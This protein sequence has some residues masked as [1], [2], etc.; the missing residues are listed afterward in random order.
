MNDEM[1]AHPQTQAN[2]ERLR[3]RGVGDRRARRSA[4]WPR[5]R[6]SGPGRMSEPETILAHAARLLR[7]AGR[8][9]R[10]AGGGDRGPDARVDRSGAGG[11]QPL[12]REDG[13]S[14]GRGGV[15]ARGRRGA[16][17]GP[18][19][20]RRAPIG[21]TRAAGRDD[22]ASSR[23]AVRE[24]LPARRRA[25]HGR[26][27]GRFPARA[28]PSDRKRARERRRAGDPDGADRPTSSSATR[29]RPAAGQRHRRLRAR[30]RRRA[31]QGA[32]QAR[33][34]GARPDRGERRARAG[35][36]LRGGHQ[37]GG[38]ARAARAR[39][40]SCRSSPSARWPR[41]FST[42]WSAPLA[43][44]RRRYLAQQIELGGAE[45][46]LGR[47]RQPRRS[48]RSPSR[49]PAEPAR[50]SS[51]RG[52]PA[53]GRADD[54]RSGR[55]ARRR[56]PGPGSPSTS[57]APVLLGNDLAALPTLDAVAERIRTTYCCELCPQS[58]QRG[59]GRGQSA[60]PG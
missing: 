16:D 7:G 59:A 55:R 46:I 39:R 53:T 42:R 22:Q 36:G 41:R 32:G 29:E 11:H 5:D 14:R 10:P 60:T 30:D 15:G 4:R 24:E 25:G 27:A 33:A 52:P 56:F 17:L 31:G 44:E 23:T 49:R 51:R 35:R 12:E 57:P 9:A 45:V 8:L 34:Q 26:G 13:L 48:A 38:A 6:R 43:D 54:R 47:R 50:A 28:S 58:H 19:G 2:L 21:V 20:A 37:P 1:Y 3:A 18:G 40:A